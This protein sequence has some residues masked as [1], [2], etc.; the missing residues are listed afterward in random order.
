MPLI[1]PW[2]DAFLMGPCL[3]HVAD[4]FPG[5]HWAICMDGAGWH[6]AYELVLPP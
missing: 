5:E 2:V 6:Q 1:L 4:T 3:P